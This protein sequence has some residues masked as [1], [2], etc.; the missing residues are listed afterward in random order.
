[1]RFALSFGRV[2]SLRHACF[3]CIMKNRKR[4][5]DKAYDKDFDNHTRK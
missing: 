1:M 4:E 2:I 5:G 3:S